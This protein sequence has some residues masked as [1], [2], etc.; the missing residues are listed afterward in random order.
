MKEIT[1]QDCFELKAKFD[2]Y[3]RTAEQHQF[4][5]LLMVNIKLNQTLERIKEFNQL[6]PQEVCR[7][8]FRVVLKIIGEDCSAYEE[9]KDGK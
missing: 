6:P 9:K 4:P 7:S 8:M 5:M 1:I 2:D 3:C